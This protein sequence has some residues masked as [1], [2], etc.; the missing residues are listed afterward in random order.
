MATFS[1]GMIKLKR[2]NVKVGKYED[3]DKAVF[4]WLMSARS[5]NMPA[6]GLVFQE[7]TSD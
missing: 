1:F 2:K 3:L 7:K 4:K 6:S 5:N